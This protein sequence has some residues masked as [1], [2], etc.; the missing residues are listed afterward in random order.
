MF[1][2]HS[3]DWWIEAYERGHR[4]PVNRVT[5]LVGIPLILVSLPLLLAGIWVRGALLAAA[6]LFSVGWV[7][8]FAGHVAERKPPEFFGDW[9]FLLVGVRWWLRTVSQR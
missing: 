7:F 6:V 8:Q 5:H 2:G 3:W 9:R 1:Y 4:H